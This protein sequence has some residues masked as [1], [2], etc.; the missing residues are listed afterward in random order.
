MSSILMSPS[1]NKRLTYGDNQKLKPTNEPPSSPFIA[2][3]KK[4]LKS[5]ERKS[6]IEEDIKRLKM[7]NP[8][9]NSDSTPQNFLEMILEISNS[10][11]VLQHTTF[12]NGTIN[13][14]KR[15]PQQQQR[16]RQ[17]NDFSGGAPAP[18]D[19]QHI[20]LTHTKEI[21]V[22]C[23]TCVNRNTGMPGRW[24]T[25]HSTSAFE[26]TIDFPG[27]KGVTI[28]IPAHGDKENRITTI[29]PTWWDK[30]DTSFYSNS[31]EAPNRKRA[32]IDNQ[33]P[34]SASL[35]KMREMLDSL[36]GPDQSA[37]GAGS[38]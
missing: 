22:Y 16:F 15:K 11:E 2:N 24:I 37:V 5:T 7:T 18:S 4:L 13:Q 27:K 3:G 10:I 12:A 34:A 9:L 29:D 31:N 33:S 28:C 17:G 23:E 20:K 8:L 1:V 32:A 26:K 38:K 30:E 36:S 19:P 14:F 6:Q 35:K 21:L 25:S